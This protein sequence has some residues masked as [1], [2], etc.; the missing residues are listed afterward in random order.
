VGCLYGDPVLRRALVPLLMVMACSCSADSSEPPEEDGSGSQVS[1]LTGG[2]GMF[3]ASSGDLPALPEGWVE[4]ELALSGFATTYT[5]EGELPT[6]GRFDLGTAFE[7]PYET[8]VVVRRPPA[9]DFNG[10]VLV[11]WLNVSGGF[12]AHPDYS[13][14]ADEILRGGYAW[15]GVSA[16]YVGIE[17]GPV[18]V[19]T[20]ASEAAGA[21]KGLR[22]LDPERYGDLDHP[23]DAFSY[24]IYSQAADAARA[25]D[26]L[27]DLEP[28]RL[29]AVGESQ[30]GFALTT[31]ANGV[32]PL[33]DTFDGFL[34]H[35]RG[36]ATAPL[37]VFDSGIDI[38]GTLGGEPTTVRDDL[39]VP[40]LTL[41]S[42]TDVVGILNYL[43]AR[44][45]DSDTFRL[46]E[47]A[48]TAHADRF[49]LGPLSDQL[50]CP[51]PVNDGPQHLVAKAA[52]RALDAW[53]RDGI[54]PPEA[55][56]LAV[57]GTA[58]ERDRDGIVQ[59]GIR[60]PL[61]D[62]P[63]DVLSG[64]PAPD[65]PLHCLLFGST[66]PLPDGRVAELYAD[67]AAYLSA[68]EAAADA[69]IDAGFVLAE[70]REALVAYAQPE[71]IT[72]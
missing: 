6:D 26:L 33:T 45:P 23:G 46:W 51:A 20:P 61:V 57:T 19:S 30:S 70:D 27:G 35:S 9:E 38:A 15:V 63:V 47:V 11:E 32:Q 10:T 2:S 53:V 64:D 55:D 67:R 21:G 36:G 41:E 54:A 40:V 69:A 13:Y 42:E 8:R 39:E 12:D 44:Q 14:L 31:Y 4:E 34:I 28:E 3:L 56:R 24:D 59:G 48:G 62:A 25:G 49:L 37:G 1:P 66:T 16:Q 18:A 7:E 50:G 43:P 72:D 22:V 29:L 17:G 68:F 65:G 5:S 71:R 52:L 60:T 58:Y